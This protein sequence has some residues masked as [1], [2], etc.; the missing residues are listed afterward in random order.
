MHA[1]QCYQKMRT[2]RK[3][4]RVNHREHLPCWDHKVAKEICDKI[5]ERCPGILINM[6]TGVVGDDLTAQME[7]LDAV[8][9]RSLFAL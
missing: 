5:R 1:K 6:S 4:A 7:C 9:S 3:H 8:P 2:W